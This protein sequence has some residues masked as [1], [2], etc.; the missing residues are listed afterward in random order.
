[1]VPLLNFCG[2]HSLHKTQVSLLS[3]QQLLQPLDQVFVPLQLGVV[4][5]AC[6]D[7]SARSLSIVAAMDRLQ[8]TVRLLGSIGASL[9]SRKSSTVEQHR[10]G[11]R[12]SKHTRLLGCRSNPLLLESL[13]TGIVCESFGALHYTRHVDITTTA[14]LLRTDR[15][16][17]REHGFVVLLRCLLLLDLAFQLDVVNFE[18]LMLFLLVDNLLEEH[19]PVVFLTEILDA[20]LLVLLH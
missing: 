5:E 2:T 18:L 13:Q 15:R 19:V 1:M 4:M 20:Q 9:G 11:S 8:A 12:T 16:P 17:A 10:C 7:S 14:L 6:T 3:L